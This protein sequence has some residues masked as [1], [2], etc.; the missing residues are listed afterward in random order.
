MLLDLAPRP[1]RVPGEQ[2]IQRVQFLVNP[3]AVDRRRYRRACGVESFELLI[4]LTEAVLPSPD[5][6][7]QPR[8]GEV[9][10]SHEGDQAGACP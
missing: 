2:L 1:G 7:V 6:L 4:K 5:L 8:G 3:S 10:L 9:P